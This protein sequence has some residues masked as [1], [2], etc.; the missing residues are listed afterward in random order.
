MLSVQ[1]VCLLRVSSERSR[2]GGQL[3]TP[4]LEHWGS[5]SF[6]VP[7]LEHRP[8]ASLDTEPGGL[9]SSPP[10]RAGHKTKTKTP[11]DTQQLAP[12]RAQLRGERESHEMER[13]GERWATH[14]VITANYYS[15]Q[16]SEKPAS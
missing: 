5:P 14:G 3:G 15:I 2:A 11:F 1:E 16:H 12:S 13:E 4:S 9:S 6:L 7:G 8:M 10:A